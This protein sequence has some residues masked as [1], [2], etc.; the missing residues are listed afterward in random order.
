M[1]AS[2]TQGGHKKTGGGLVVVPCARPTTCQMSITCTAG[3][4]GCM[5]ACHTAD[6]CFSWNQ[7]GTGTHV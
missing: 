3:K 1:S 6:Q 7:K 4:T 5:T 2:A